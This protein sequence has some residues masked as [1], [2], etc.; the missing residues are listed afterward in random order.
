[1][2]FDSTFSSPLIYFHMLHLGAFFVLIGST[3]TFRTR[4]LDISMNTCILESW[5]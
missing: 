1:M 2:L 4:S 5:Y 3:A